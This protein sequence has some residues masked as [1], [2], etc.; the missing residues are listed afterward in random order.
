MTRTKFTAW[1]YEDEYRFVKINL[2][3]FKNAKERIVIYEQ[4]AL[5]EVILGYNIDENSKQ[6]ILKEVE[7]NFSHVKVYQVDIDYTSFKLL[8]RPV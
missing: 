4:D 7:T 1:Q 2:N 8:I 3:N 6:E 5:R